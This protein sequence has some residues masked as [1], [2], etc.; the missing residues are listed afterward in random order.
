VED[1]KNFPREELR[2]MD[3]LWVKYSNGKFGFSVQKQIWLESGGKLNGERDWDT[4]TKL[5][6]RVGWK[7]NGG[8]LNYDSYTFSTNAPSGHLPACGWG[9]SKFYSLWWDGCGLFFSLL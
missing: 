2:K 1:V 5:G 9:E 8:W 6:D 3:Q 7:Q 4:F